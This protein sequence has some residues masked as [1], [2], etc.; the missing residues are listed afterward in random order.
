[1]VSKAED[2]V[3]AGREMS[4]DRSRLEYLAESARQDI[5]QGLLNR[6]LP[7]PHYRALFDGIETLSH[8]KWTSRVDIQEWVRWHNHMAELYG[9]IARVVGVV[10]VVPKDPK[11]AITGL[12]HRL[13]RE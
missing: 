8:R 4:W 9:D 13:A 3:G 12:L 7:E 10:R 2:G 11:P 5:D 1:M 6:D